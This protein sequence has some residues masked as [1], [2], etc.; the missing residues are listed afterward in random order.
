M[1][2]VFE[3]WYLII[4]IECSSN[5]LV[6]FMVTLLLTGGTGFL[7][8]YIL[9]E[10]E[11][12]NLSDELGIS[13]IRLLVRNLEKAVNITSKKYELEILEGDL[14][15]PKSLEKIGEGVNY[16]IHTAALYSTWGK[17]SEFFKINVDG[18]KGLIESLDSCSA[19]I[20]TSTYGIYGFN[21][22][23]G[24]PIPEDFDNKQPFW[25]YQES[26]KAQEDVARELCQKKK[27][28]FIALRA[29]NIIGPGDFVGAYGMM[30]NIE[31]RRVILLRGGKNKLPISHPKDV[32]RA[33]VLAL[34]KNEQFKSESFNIASL[35]VPFKEYVNTYAKQMS[36]KPI[37]LKAPYWLMYGFASFLDFFPI[38]HDITRF[39]VKFLGG[40]NILDTTKMKEELEL[41][42][43]YDSLEP[44][45][46]E[47]VS[48]YQ[49]IKTD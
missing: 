22:N 28:N 39:T 14:L 45:I 21:V 5:S 12:E 40:H 48:W 25:H 37:K 36:E 24:E 15:E 43:E 20:L 6:R 34:K 29:P 1:G 16:V 18:T 35:H 46:K 26:K 13:T 47:T 2:K 23:N 3:D 8:S 30:R 19:F 11:K 32:A 9:R 27:I 42:P 38:K 7:G 41:Q 31:K 33:H 17:R 4:T 49:T 10:L 44:I